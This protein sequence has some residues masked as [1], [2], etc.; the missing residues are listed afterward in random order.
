MLKENFL[1]FDSIEKLHC[2]LTNIMLISSESSNYFYCYCTNDGKQCDFC[3]LVH[4]LCST[5]NLIDGLPPAKFLKFYHSSRE[6]LES[7][8]DRIFLFFEK[9]D[10]NCSDAL[11]FF[12]KEYEWV[13]KDIQ[14]GT[15]STMT[16]TEIID[17]DKELVKY[18]PHLFDRN[19]LKEHPEI[20]NFEYGFLN[21]D[22]TFLLDYD[23]I[24]YVS[25]ISA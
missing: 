10:R 11:D 15:C 6:K 17:S 20:I 25:F 19:F 18:N 7:F 22:I 3:D 21:D 9:I 5:E 12:N 14:E 4:F 24:L 8:R 23:I 13:H 1:K 16:L 2:E